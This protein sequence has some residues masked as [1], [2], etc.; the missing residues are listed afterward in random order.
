MRAS[1]LAL[2]SAHICDGFQISF[3]FHMHTPFRELTES[4]ILFIVKP[5]APYRPASAPPLPW[6]G[7]SLTQ[8]VLIPCRAGCTMLVLPGSLLLTINFLIISLPQARSRAG[9]KDESLY[10]LTQYLDVPRMASAFLTAVVWHC[11]ILMQALQKFILALPLSS[12]LS[13]AS[14]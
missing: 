13:V 5:Q 10:S 12:F 2:S 1:L 8:P 9:R 7:I 6:S 11:V 14:M 3:P 4:K